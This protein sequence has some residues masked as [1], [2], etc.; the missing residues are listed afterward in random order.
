MLLKFSNAGHDIR[1][2]N[3]SNDMFGVIMEQ[4]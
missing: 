3:A 4:G 2:A 1:M